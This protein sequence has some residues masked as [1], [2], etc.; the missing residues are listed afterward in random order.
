MA[1]IPRADTHV[2]SRFSVDSTADP[3]EVCRAAVDAG[4]Q[5]LCFA[6]HVDL[7]PRDDGYGYFCWDAYRRAVD[8]TRE[9]FAGRLDILLGLEIG[10]PHRYPREMERLAALGPDVLIGSIHWLP[11][12]FV[13]DRAVCRTMGIGGLFRAYYREM[14][15]AARHGGFDVLAHLD[16]PKRYHGRAPEDAETAEAIGAIMAEASAGGLAL[17][18]NTSP[19]RK[20]RHECTPDIDILA[21][22]AAT[23]PTPRVTLGSDAHTPEEVGAGLDRAQDLVRRAG[24]GPVGIYRARRFIALS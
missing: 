22:Y 3:L 2:H 19:L 1:S 6:E 23:S 8:E 20:G 18:V 12:G 4:L 21:R 24:A 11:E 15:D 16:F 10:E 17:E 5:Y 14:L 9:R 7:D 13:G